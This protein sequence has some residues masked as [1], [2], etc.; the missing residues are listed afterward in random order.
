MNNFF[1]LLKLPKWM[2]IKIFNSIFVVKHLLHKI[3]QI[4]KGIGGVLGCLVCLFCH[5][6]SLQAQTPKVTASLD[7]YQIEIGE[8]VELTWV[9]EHTSNTAIQFP[10]L[11]LERNENIEV[12]EI[13][14]IK[15][16]ELENGL[17]KKTQTILVQAWDTGQYVIPSVQFS[18]SNTSNSDRQ[19]KINTEEL[20]FFVTTP[21]LKDLPPPNP[22]DTTVTVNAELKEIKGIK[23]MPFTWRDAIPYLLIGLVILFMLVIL[24]YW[25]RRKKQKE[26]EVAAYVPPPRPAHEVA[27]EKLRVL[28]DA[29]YWQQGAVKKY[30]SEL[31]DIVRE[32]LERRYDVQALES[33]TDEILE[34]LKKV[35]FEE[36][37]WEK[38]KGMLQ[39]A[40]LV[41]FAK[42]RPNIESHSEYLKDAKEMVRLT[43]KKIILEEESTNESQN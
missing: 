21:L 41:K 8:Q 24:Y 15:S 4:L 18:Y 37:L 1:S 38:L 42:A 3:A 39:T 11:N 34:G 16:A 26:G 30:Y 12:T 31:T 40:D 20:A 9:V 13:Q 19:S 32:Y 25:W 28:E 10:A 27:F 29:K 7:R 36:N 33:T 14:D 23:E 5:C 35:D 6:T 22:Q 2:M 43:K 17:I